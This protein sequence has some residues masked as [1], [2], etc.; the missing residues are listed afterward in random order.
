MTAAWF[1]YGPNEIISSVLGPCIP[2]V[3]LAPPESASFTVISTSHANGIPT[4]LFGPMSML[5]SLRQMLLKSWSL[6]SYIFCLQTSRT[7][8]LL[9]SLLTFYLFILMNVERAHKGVKE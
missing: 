6:A 8:F 2:T 1:S 9:F 3:S 7:S 5:E 4:P